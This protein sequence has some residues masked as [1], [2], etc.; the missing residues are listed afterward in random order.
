M[1]KYLLR[2]GKTWPNTCLGW[3]KSKDNY[4]FRV[5]F[6]S[7]REHGVHLSMAVVPPPPPR[8]KYQESFRYWIQLI[9]IIIFF[10]QAMR[11]SRRGTSLASSSGPSM[12]AFSGR[13]LFYTRGWRF[14]PP[15]TSSPRLWTDRRVNK[16]KWHNPTILSWISQFG[17]SSL[18]ACQKKNKKKKKE[19][20]KD[21][22]SQ[23]S[24]NPKRTRGGRNLPPSTF[25][26]II[27]RTFFSAPQAFMTF[28]FEVLRNI[29]RNFLKNR[30]YGS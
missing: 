1:T 29:W 21:L 19:E 9:C 30:A 3:G 6:E 28:F 24:L 12:C 10:F 14:L 17:V 11:S 2:V 18:H 25:R 22:S 8:E 4:L 16:T 23:R 27:S 26:A 13:R 20:K 5:H 15:S 7:V